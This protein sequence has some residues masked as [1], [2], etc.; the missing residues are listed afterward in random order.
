V[1]LSIAATA[2]AA[3]LW[4]TAGPMLGFVRENQRNRLPFDSPR[5]KSHSLDGQDAMWPTRLR[6]VDDLLGSR[7]LL[8]LPS[9]KVVAL[10]GPDD[11]EMRG[12][13]PGWDRC[14]FLGPARQKGVFDFRWMTSEWLV[15]RLAAD[16]RVVQQRIEEH[17]D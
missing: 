12:D 10:L 1:T 8:G 15:L 11:K 13:F 17:N 9:S 7:R 6:M 16:G 5:W 4:F 2:I 3:L 14:Y